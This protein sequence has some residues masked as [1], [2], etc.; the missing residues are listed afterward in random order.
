VTETAVVTTTHATP[1]ATTPIPSQPDNEAAPWEERLQSFS[2]FTYQNLTVGQEFAFVFEFNLKTMKY[3]PAIM[4]RF[5]LMVPVMM[6][7]SELNSIP[8]TIFDLELFMAW[9]LCCSAA[10]TRQLLW[11]MHKKP[12]DVTRFCY[13]VYGM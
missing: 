3:E 7:C 6:P 10:K 5:G 8:P 2:D 4:Q 12:H 11:R 1:V 9:K 13:R